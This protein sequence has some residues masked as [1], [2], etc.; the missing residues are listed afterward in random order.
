MEK[1]EINDIEQKYERIL[2]T[3]DKDTLIMFLNDIDEKEEN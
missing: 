3:Y 2:N 1:A